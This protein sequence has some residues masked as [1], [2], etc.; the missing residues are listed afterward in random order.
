ALAGA[1]SAA[2]LPPCAVGSTYSFT[3]WPG[4]STCTPA[5]TTTCPGARPPA[6]TTVLPSAP[7]TW[8]GCA[9][10]TITPLSFLSTNHT[11]VRPCSSVTAA[12]GR[13]TTFDCCGSSTSTVA[14]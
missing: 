1:A 6:T 2:G 11:A 13:R 3:C 8:I 12:S 5:V 14:V 9:L 7:A 10:T 4:D